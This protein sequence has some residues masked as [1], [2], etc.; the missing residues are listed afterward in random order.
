MSHYFDNKIIIVGTGPA[1]LT[2][3]Y[4]LLL[5]NVRPIIIDSASV[6]GGFM[7]NITYKEYN[8]DIGRKEMYTRINQ[9]N[10]LWES[11][12]KNDYKK[13]DY[14]VGVLYKGNILEMN[15][16]YLGIKRGM[17]NK[18][19]LKGIFSFFKS[20]WKYRHPKNLQEFIYK[21]H[22]KLFTK[23][24]QQ[25]FW[26]RFQGRL[27]NNV[28]MANVRKIHKAKFPFAYF[29]RKFIFD[30]FDDKNSQEFWR[31]P[32][33]G[34]EQII[35]KLVEEIF[36]LKGK[37]SYET[38]IVDIHQK[39][40]SIISMDLS[41]DGEIVTIHPKM[42]ISSISI[43]NLYR[44]IF[45]DKSGLIKNIHSAQRG[46]ILVYIFINGQINFDN[47][48]VNVTC[49]NLKIGRI[50]DFSKFNG[51]M[52][53]NGKSCLCIEFF[54]N[55]DSEMF[56]LHDDEIIQIAI[57]ES[58]TAKIFD[59]NDIEHTIVLKFK[60][61]NA[62][63]TW[64]DFIHDPQKLKIH[65]TLIKM[66][67]LFNIN[68]VGADRATHAGIVAANSIITNDKVTFE[69]LTD[70]TKIDPWIRDS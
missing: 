46:D 18:T 66:E 48:W 31:H 17:S 37:I 26:E 3:A 58:N 32:S 50:T 14:R 27:W 36:R 53:P 21:K 38:K 29:I 2:C 56:D 67:N 5:N 54:L 1:A 63:G 20:K 7:R 10:K 30:Q 6:P 28:P 51:E 24:F 64:E 13:Y 55:S 43:E 60:N 4:K 70:P 23:M 12:L 65:K 49:P 34:C 8:I 16:S 45:K 69:K 40:N 47:T 39:E 11:L 68:R 44:M 9:V 62:A 25:G 15:S 41:I 59:K 33:K 19:F 22:G 57:R 52:V 35:H 42:V 61:A